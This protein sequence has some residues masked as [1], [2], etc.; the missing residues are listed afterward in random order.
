MHFRTESHV[1]FFRVSPCARIALHEKSK[2]TLGN[3]RTKSR[4]AILKKNT[5]VRRKQAVPYQKTCFLGGLYLAVFGPFWASP[6]P[7]VAGNGFSAKNDSQF[8]G[9]DSNPCPGGPFRGNFSFLKVT[10]EK[11][12][13]VYVYVVCFPPIHVYMHMG[14]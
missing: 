7:G 12:A 8:R 14:I 10:P 2:P 13:K 11:M 1:P 9:R 4:T 6:G 3:F 5:V